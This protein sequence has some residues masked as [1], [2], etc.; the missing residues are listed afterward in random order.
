M[1][2]HHTMRPLPNTPTEWQSEIASA[3]ADAFETLPFMPLVDVVPEESVLFHLA[4]RVAIKFRGLSDDQ[5]GIATE[6]ALS[7][8]I[9][10]KDQV[11]AAL[12][13]PRIA[14]AFCYLAAQFG[15]N[16]V[17]EQTAAQVMAFIE[18]DKDAFANAI[19]E[20][21]RNGKH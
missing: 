21:T 6:A 4:P 3:Y 7:S 18:Q 20:K 17:A 19:N 13:D 9:A 2:L 11:G 15:L 1:T 5:V 16:I 10:S 8:Y 14:F 12:D